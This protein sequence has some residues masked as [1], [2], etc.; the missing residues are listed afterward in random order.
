MTQVWVLTD[1]RYLTQRMPSALVDWLQARGVDVQVACPDTSVLEVAAEGEPWSSLARAGVVVTRSRHPLT[2]AVLAGLPDFVPALPAAGPVAR[3]RDKV[4]VARTLARCDVPAP[5]TLVAAGAPAFRSL[6][7][8]WFPL[9]VKPQFG[10]NARGVTVVRG[11][12]ELEDIPPGDGLAVAQP[13]L[14][15]GGID[16]K[17]YLAGEATWAV[18]RPSPIHGGAGGTSELCA[19]SE[20]LRTLALRCRKGFDL[21]LL[22]LDVLETAA[23]PYV[24]DVNEFPNY[25][26]VEEAP[27]VIGELVLAR[28]GGDGP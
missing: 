6:P 13:Y 5:P 18:R 3:V 27:A 4:E 9:V 10:D 22:G 23:G 8:S 17:L 19:V 26:G 20:D 2:L 28:L 15:A 24:V 25:T 14:D 21:D 16:L 1:E 11:P 7:S 12:D